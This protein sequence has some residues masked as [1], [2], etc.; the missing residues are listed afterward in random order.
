[1]NVPAISPAKWLKQ[2]ASY[3]AE[4]NITSQLKNTDLASGFITNITE[5]VVIDKKQYIVQTF[6]LETIEEAS[7]L[8]KGFV[9]N[10][11]KVYPHAVIKT[12]H[13]DYSFLSPEDQYKINWAYG[14]PILSEE[15]QK[16]TDPEEKNKILKQITKSQRLAQ[17]E[18][19][20]KIEKLPLK[21][22]VVFT[23]VIQ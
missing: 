4:F 18:C 14:A 8:I 12:T 7:N 1:M 3:E 19:Q 22:K 2:V 20:T 11:R 6:V 10:G 17:I 16:I 15:E 13:V 23:V 9:V 5:P 21:N